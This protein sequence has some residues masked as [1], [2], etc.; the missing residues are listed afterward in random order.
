[1]RN[2]TAFFMLACILTLAL[3]FVLGVI[4]FTP[5]NPEW[6]A[7]VALADAIGV[8]CFLWGDGA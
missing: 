8:C 3:I 2:N 1:M 6:W 7:I 5:K 4:G